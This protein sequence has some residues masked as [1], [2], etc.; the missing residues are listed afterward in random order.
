GLPT[1]RVPLGA[2][3][4]LWFR[5]VVPDMVELRSMAVRCR[6]QVSERI[7]R[8]RR[9]IHHLEN[10][11]V[12]PEDLPRLPPPRQ[13]EFQIELVPRAAP[14]ARAPYRLAP[15]EMQELSNQLQELTDK[16]KANVIADALSRKERIK[17]LRVRALIMTIHNNFPTHTLGAQVEATF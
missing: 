11:K 12:F 2:Y 9:V 17:S 3:M 1:D 7:L 14:V 16:G 15:S 10:V 8:R 6:T 5:G 4:G 13:V